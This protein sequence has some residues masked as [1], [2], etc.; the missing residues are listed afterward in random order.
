MEDHRDELIV[1]VAGYPDKMDE[2]LQS[3]PGLMSR[4]NK[5]I[6]FDDYMPQDLCLILQRMCDKNGYKMDEA[7][8]EKASKMITVLHEGRTGNFANARSI[9]NLFE[10]LLTIH[11]DRMEAIKEPTDNELCTLI[12]LD[13]DA[14]ELSDLMR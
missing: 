7:A 3:N 6:V 13:L 14:V 2:F 5:F 12:E 11:A 4:F 9:R 8:S 1:I 10:K